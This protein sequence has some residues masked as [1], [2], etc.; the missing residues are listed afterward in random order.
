MTVI[1]PGLEVMRSGTDQWVTLGTE[2]IVSVGGRVRSDASGQAQIQLFDG[3]TLV[4]LRPS[5]EVAITRMERND[6]GFCV[7]IGLLS[8]GTRQTLIPVPETYIGYPRRRSVAACA[9]TGNGRLRLG[10]TARP[11]GQ[12]GHHS[13]EHLPR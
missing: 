12:R 8:G 3:A 13:L 7:G 5:T 1:Q 6:E 9:S 11:G 10:V 4:A 2:S